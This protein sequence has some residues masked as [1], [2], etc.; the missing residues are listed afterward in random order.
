MKVRAILFS[1]ASV[2]FLMLFGCSTDEEKPVIKIAL[3]RASPVDSYINY[4]NWV[5]SAD[6]TIICQDLYNMPLDSAMSIFRECSGLILTGGT[7]INPVLYDNPEDS[8]RC[9]TI[10][11]YRDQ[12][13]MMLVDS[14]MAWGTPVLGI[15][16]GH[17]MLNVA[18]GG[19]LIIDI[20]T[21]YDTTVLHRCEDFLTCFHS[22]EIESGSMLNEISGLENGTVN[23]NH[24]QGIKVLA[25]TLKVVAYAADGLPEAVE[26]EHPEGKSFILGVQWHPERL[27]LDNP[28][29]AKILE[30][31]VKECYEF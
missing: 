8:G 16:R 23:S 24:H 20:P 5:K 9:M 3:S 19:S 1:L 27:G 22:V 7:D 15:C 30:R 12:L 17:Q 31:F 25:P 29:S 6:S 11:D 28:L 10:D 2:F 21:D 18:F 26:W 13:E 14:A 4:Y